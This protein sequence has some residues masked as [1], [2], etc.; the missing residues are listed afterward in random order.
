MWDHYVENHSDQHSDNID[1]KFEILNN[2]SDPMT[3]QI[4]EAVRINYSLKS[5]L[6]ID[7]NGKKQNIKSLNRKNEHF[8]ARKRFDI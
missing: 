1:F 7:R 4:E 2:F 5:G 8:A 6:H 3:R